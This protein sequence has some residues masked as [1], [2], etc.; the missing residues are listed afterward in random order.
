ME[1]RQLIE[2]KATI[3]ASLD[4]VWEK[5]TQAQHIIH[6]N[7]AHESWCC[8]SAE[9]DFKEGGSSN[10]RMEAKDGSFGFNLIAVFLTID[11][12]QSILSTLEDGRKVSVQFTA[13][14]NQTTITQQ[15]E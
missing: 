12:K 2:V 5:W 9:V 8:P 6:W 4:Q 10:Y 15:F 14:N 13:E 7:F 1:N 11:P 3:H